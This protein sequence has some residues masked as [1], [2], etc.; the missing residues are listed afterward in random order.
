M[1]VVRGPHGLPRSS[2]PSLRGSV[3]IPTSGL[4]LP[5]AD[6]P[7]S[8]S[9]SA[10]RQPAEGESGAE[11]SPYGPV[12]VTVVVCCTVCVTVTVFEI[13]CVTVCVCVTVWVWVWVCVCVWVTGGRVCV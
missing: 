13:V 7:W 5:Q 4:F 2:D 3:A 6:R 10:L 8:G 11:R 9:R 1:V 12:T